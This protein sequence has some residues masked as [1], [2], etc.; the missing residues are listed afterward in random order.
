MY[1]YLMWET[2]AAQMQPCGMDYESSARQRKTP[3]DLAF[4]MH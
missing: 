4:H 1:C 2:G 3:L